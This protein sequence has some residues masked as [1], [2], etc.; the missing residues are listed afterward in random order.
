MAD[1]SFSVL[2]RMSRCNT[3]YKLTKFGLLVPF[4]LDLDHSDPY[5]FGRAE[6]KLIVQSSRPLVKAP[7]ETKTPRLATYPPSRPSVPTRQPTF[8]LIIISHQGARQKKSR[9]SHLP[10]SS[11]WRTQAV[12]MGVA[13]RWAALALVA[14]TGIA[15]LLP[16]FGGHYSKGPVDHGHAMGLMDFPFMEADGR[17][18]VKVWACFRGRAESVRVHV[19]SGNRN[20]GGHG[21]V[22]DPLCLPCLD[23]PPRTVRLCVVTPCHH[24]THTSA[25][26]CLRLVGVACLL[27]RGVAQRSPSPQ[28]T[29][30]P[31]KL[32]GERCPL[33]RAAQTVGPPSTKRAATTR[34]LLTA[35]KSSC[36]TTYSLATCSCTSCGNRQAASRSRASTPSART[37]PACSRRSP[38]RSRRC[39]TP[40]RTEQWRSPSWWAAS[41]TPKGGRAG[42]E[43]RAQLASSSTSA[44]A[45]HSTRRCPGQTSTRRA[46]AAARAHHL[47]TKVL[48]CSSFWQRRRSRPPSP[49]PRARLPP[50]DSCSPSDALSHWRRIRVPLQASSPGGG[51][52]S[53]GAWPTRT[54]GRLTPW[55]TGTERAPSTRAAGTP[56]KQVRS[57]C[58]G[59]RPPA[60]HRPLQPRLILFETGSVLRLARTCVQCCGR[61]S[62]RHPHPA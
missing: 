62:L 19:W 24:T 59:P 2:R 53:R 18:S 58:L 43:W 61:P 11:R 23:A 6:L 8:S 14:A 35:H 44:S 13:T 22:V 57:S 32:R 15:H 41:G 28:P 25:S 21:T 16:V 50:P 17:W 55:A 27:L 45:V 47:N 37:R 48:M 7:Q 54:H 38:T 46:C 40:S 34:T 31:S 51:R 36:P 33:A 30:P 4:F 5:L 49:H 29:N 9:C 39:L 10:R 60:H 20:K 42:T 12:A 1:V 26:I 3:E 56:P 52:R